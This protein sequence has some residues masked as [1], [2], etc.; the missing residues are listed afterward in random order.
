MGRGGGGG[1]NDPPRLIKVSKRP[2]NGTMM[3]IVWWQSGR[4]ALVAVM[5]HPHHIRSH[6]I[7]TGN[8]LINNERVNEKKNAKRR[9]MSSHQR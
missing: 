4:Q 7:I 3:M 9:N 6:P 1:G 5:S 8:K 2:S